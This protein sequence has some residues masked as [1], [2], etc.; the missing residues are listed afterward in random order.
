MSETNF[1]MVASAEASQ[2]TSR[3]KK[4]IP[5]RKVKY[6]LAIKTDVCRET[7]FG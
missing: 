6:V 2:L 3:Q 4:E 1:L 7:R 5:G